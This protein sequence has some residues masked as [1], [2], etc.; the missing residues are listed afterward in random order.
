MIGNNI[1]L[2]ILTIKGQQ[3]RVGIDAPKDVEI[4]REE[5]ITRREEAKRKA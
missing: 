3:V 5:I 2:T 1:I 4:L